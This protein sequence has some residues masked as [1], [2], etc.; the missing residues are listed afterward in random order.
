MNHQ[1]DKRLKIENWNFSQWVY[2]HLF[3][4]YD[5]IVKITLTVYENID[6]IET[7]IINKKKLLKLK[8]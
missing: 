8:S 6:F 4:H 7:S 2:F 1:N 5:K 3:Y